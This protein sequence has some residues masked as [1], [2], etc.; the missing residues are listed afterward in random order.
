MNF[1][2]Q[3]RQVDGQQLAK[4]ARLSSTQA[5]K[6]IGPEPLMHFLRE[7]GRTQFILPNGSVN[8]KRLR[9]EL[10]IG[11]KLRDNKQYIRKMD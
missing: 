8:I 1:Y 5:L 6:Q 7:T 4:I 3:E 2:M 9:E 11:K 10:A